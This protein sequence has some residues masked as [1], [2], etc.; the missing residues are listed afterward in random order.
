MVVGVGIDQVGTFGGAVCSGHELLP[1]DGGMPP[2]V[3]DSVENIHDSVVAAYGSR[4]ICTSDR[5]VAMRVAI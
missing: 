5:V 1:V 4:A 3:K 2:L